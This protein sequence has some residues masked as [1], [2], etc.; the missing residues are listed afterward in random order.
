VDT[1]VRTISLEPEVAGKVI[2]VFVGETAPDNRVKKGDKVLEIDPRLYTIKVEEAQWTVV[3]AKVEV[4]KAELDQEMVTDQLQVRR[5]SLKA[6]SARVEQA[7]KAVEVIREQ[8][9]IAAKVGTL[10]SAIG[11][12]NLQSA[13]AVVTGFKAME[14]VEKKQVDNFEKSGPKLAAQA[15]QV[16]RARFKAATAALDEANRALE[17]CTLKAPADGSILQLNVAEGGVVAPGSPMPFVVF[18]PAG[19]LVVRADLEQEFVYRVKP[20]MKVEL[21]DEARSNSPLWTG[22]VV[23]VSEFIARKRNILLDPGEMNDVRT[24]ECVISVDPSTETLRIGQRMRVRIQ[25]R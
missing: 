4:D 10:P 7:E 24:A 14:A 1:S 2:K 18:A 3:A 15:L 22:K 11:Q 20:G 16:A 9:R 6:A 5:E 12:L 13:E 17:E 21:R 8:E 19:P 23:T 25:T